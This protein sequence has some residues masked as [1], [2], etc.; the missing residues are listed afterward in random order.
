MHPLDS[1]LNAAMHSVDLY[2]TPLALGVCEK[3]AETES[4]LP[5]I[6]PRL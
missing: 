5:I 1:P 2:L 6:I 4:T 3:G